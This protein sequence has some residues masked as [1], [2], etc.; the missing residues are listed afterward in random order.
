M[1]NEVS[2]PLNN[3]EKLEATEQQLI[4]FLREHNEIEMILPVV[5]GVFISSRFQLRGANALIANLAI[6]SI[7]RQIFINL[8]KITPTVAA[9]ASIPGI[10][11]PTTEENGEYTI[12]HSVNGRI[13]LKIPRIAEDYLFSSNL[14]ELLEED[15]HVIKAR[16]NRAAASV[17]INYEAEGLSDIELGLRLLSIMNK[18]KETP[19]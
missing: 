9:P 6:A 14:M 5:L 7:F 3:E 17:I 2:V 18:A 15:D 13:R 1:I 11:T 8:K 19:S 16:I 12:V 10:A 4:Q